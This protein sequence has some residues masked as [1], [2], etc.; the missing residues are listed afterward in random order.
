MC[1]VFLKRHAI[2]KKLFHPLL[3]S[4]SDYLLVMDSDIL[5]FKRSKDIQHCVQNSLPFYVDG[6]VGAYIRNQQFMQ[7]QL[8]LSP[9]ESVNTGMIGYPRLQFLDLPFIE[10][11]L[12]KLINVPKNLVAE[13]IGYRDASVDPDSSD[14]NKTLCWWVM[15]QTIYALLMGRAPQTQM[16]ACWSDKKVT[17]MRGDL[18]HFTSAP[19]MRGTALVHYISDRRHQRFFP[20]GVEHLLRRGFLE[21]LC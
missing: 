11:A 12:N 19:I 4:K 7:A 15:E 8:G 3:L 1:Q 20:I 5:W 9:A 21:S 10:A 13:S 18:H 2:A 16:L 6:R 17:Q 14:I